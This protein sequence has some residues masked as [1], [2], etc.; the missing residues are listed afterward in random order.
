MRTGYADNRCH[1]KRLCGKYMFTESETLLLEHL[2][3]Q[4]ISPL[5][6]NGQWKVFLHF[7]DLY[8]PFST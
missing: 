6:E 1:L 5:A 8:A 4:H 2:K 7:N 3:I